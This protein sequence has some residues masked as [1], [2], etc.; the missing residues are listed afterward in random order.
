MATF[1][2]Q[3][4][5]PAVGEHIDLVPIDVLREHGGGGIG[6]GQ[7]L[8]VCGYPIITGD[9]HAGRGAVGGEQHVGAEIDSSQIGQFAIGRGDD[10]GVE[11]ELLGSIGDPAFAE[12]F[13]GDGRH[14]A[15]AQHRPH[16]HFI[17]TG[18][19][20]RH[21]ADAVRVGDAEQLAGQIDGVLKARLAEL[22]TMRA[23]KG[24]NVE[25]FGAPARALGARTGRKMRA[26][27]K[28]G[29]FGSHVLSSQR[30][31]AALGRHG[32][33]PGIGLWAVGSSGFGFTVDARAR[34][35]PTDSTMARP[36]GTNWRLRSASS[37]LAANR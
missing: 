17:G 10:G 13:P 21:D 27:R 25:L 31:R 24:N 4:L 35:Q 23:A 20:G 32:P 29:R 14:R 2:A 12:A 22:G 30:A 18:V 37:D 34:L 5:L 16:R 6:E 36:S 26:R 3:H 1:A 15:G 7:A 28:R 11:L 19:A 33:P 9:A 8:T